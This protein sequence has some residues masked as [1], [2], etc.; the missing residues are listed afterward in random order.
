[1]TNDATGQLDMLDSKSSMY[2]P[3]GTLNTSTPR[4]ARPGFN[5]VDGNGDPATLIPLAGTCW[6]DWSS[7]RLHCRSLTC[8]TP[9]VA[10]TSRSSTRNPAG[11]TGC[12][13]HTSGSVAVSRVAA[14]RVTDPL[15]ASPGIPS[16]GAN[17]IVSPTLPS[18]TI[19]DPP[20]ASTPEVSEGDD[21]PVW[22]PPAELHPA[23]ASTTAAITAAAV[24]RMR[25]TVRGFTVMVSHAPRRRPRAGPGGTPCARS[26]A[27]SWCRR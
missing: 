14:C 2:E 26:A 3:G 25:V 16:S 15:I 11:S 24:P 1:M 5:A 22:S 13:S 8:T 10:A 7:H 4:A 23:N 21:A 19:G 6:N 9:A 20:S 27:G 17:L 12:G 18:R